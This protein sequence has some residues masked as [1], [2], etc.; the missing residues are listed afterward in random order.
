MIPVIVRHEQYIQLRN[1]LRRIDVAPAKCA[2]D[3]KNRR[4]VVGE[5]GIDNHT[6]PADL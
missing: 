1:V 4:A 2:V 5:Y 3:E 6:P